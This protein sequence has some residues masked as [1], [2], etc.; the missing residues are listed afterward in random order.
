[1]NLN[2]FKLSETPFG[3]K[4]QKCNLVNKDNVVHNLFLIYL[5]LR[6]FINIYMYRAAVCPSSSK[7]GFSVETDV[8][9]HMGN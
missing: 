5:F 3:H 8:I 2:T 7:P 4:V 1:M 9:M 6:I